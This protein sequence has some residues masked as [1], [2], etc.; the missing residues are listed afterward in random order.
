MLNKINLIIGN[1]LQFV[2]QMKP[3]AIVTGNYMP[4]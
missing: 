2:Y 1:T 4:M 3:G